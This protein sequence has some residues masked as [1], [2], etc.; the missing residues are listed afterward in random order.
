MI[1][2]YQPSLFS[3]IQDFLNAE[4]LQNPYLY[5]DAN[6]YGLAGNHIHTYLVRQEGKIRLLIYRYYNSFQLLVNSAALPAE[7]VLKEVAQFIQSHQPVMISG[8]T[9]LITRLKTYLPAYGQTDGHLF[10][11]R[12]IPK[13]TAGTSSSF[14][15]AHTP[16]E[17]ERLASFITSDLDIGSHYTVEQL[18][19]QLLE[20][21]EKYGCQNVFL[22][23]DGRVIAHLG[24]YACYKNLAVMGGLLIDP[25]L[26]GKG[27]GRE[28][29]TFL[30]EQCMERFGQQPV[31]YCYKPTLF[32]FYHTCG[33][34]QIYDCSKLELIGDKHA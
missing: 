11:Y 1:E 18:T 34:Q 13:K 22:E 12:A 32:N 3:E 19:E 21:H 5:I 10:K 27:L 25:C 26:R 20:R 15:W 9:P 30:S 2:T 4:P 14:R 23:R 8:I 17:F 6:T 31:L 7:T 33:Y 29:M 16:Q 24:T 28:V